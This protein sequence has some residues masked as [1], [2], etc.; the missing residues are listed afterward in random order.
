MVNFC[1]FLAII[2]VLVGGL[3][4]ARGEEPPV[5]DA[6]RTQLAE[7]APMPEFLTEARIGE[8]LF[9][10]KVGYVHPFVSLA[11]YYTD[12]LF[13]RHD[14]K[15]ED[16]ITVF[17]PG[18]WVA[19]PAMS[20]Q[21]LQV[22]TLS[23][24]PGGLDVTRFPIEV[25]RRLQAYGLYRAD[26]TRH[27]DFSE[28]D[29]TYQRAEGLLNYNFRGGLS[30]ELLH[31]YELE[32]NPYG[33]GDAPTELDEFTSNLTQFLANY[34]ITPKTRIRGDLSRYT[35]EYDEDRNAFRERQDM[36]AS[37][38]GF[39]RMLPKSSVLLQYEFIDVDY[40]ENEVSDSQEHRLLAGLYW[41][42]T[43]KTRGTIRFGYSWR[44]VEA[45]DDR[46]EA[47]GE[48]RLDHR[49]TPK[50]SAYVLFSRRI[51]ETDIRDTQDMLSHRLQ[52][53]YRQ[54]LTRR[55]TGTID[56]YYYQNDYRGTRAFDGV[57]REREDELLGAKVALGYR[58]R[59]WL[60][61]ALSYTYVERDSN[62]PT[63]NYTNNTVF[64]SLT[65]AL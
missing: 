12:N 45:A 27:Q 28:E 32:Q 19:F 59:S 61:S 40:D 50:T 38:A 35:L 17:T 30:L 44:E 58:F 3:E 53:G 21:P 47:I 7:V 29:N 34:Q 56:A 2:F 26:I 8:E 39:Y 49:F 43:V 10:S 13:N 11:Q 25:Y 64:L 48:V 51:E 33:T 9:G 16:F 57:L 6:Q 42:V 60:A 5:P 54:A 31:V 22:S 62:V 55:L 63:Y 52:V 36:V 4:G 15:D 23:S 65:A 41:D 37:L 24:T 1:R 46:D 18:V 20:Q 14:D